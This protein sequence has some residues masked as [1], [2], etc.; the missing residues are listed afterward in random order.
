MILIT[1]IFCFSIS[2]FGQKKVQKSIQPAKKATKLNN[3]NL[4]KEDLKKIFTRM[5]VLANF[6]GGPQKWFDF[7]QNNFDFSYVV[8]QLSDSTKYFQDSAV[9]KFIVT[10]KGQ[11]CDI[12]FL[13]GNLLLGD[14]IIKVLNLSPNWVPASSE[15]RNLNAYRTLK[16]EIIIDKQKRQFKISRNTNDFYQEND[17]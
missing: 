11:L 2:S 1:S 6:N 14:Q 15:G 13:R 17:R 8:T 5:D 9:I 10:R 16:T 4:S 7:V 3:C 12:K